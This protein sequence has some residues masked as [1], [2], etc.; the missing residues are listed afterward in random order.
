MMVYQNQTRKAFFWFVAVFLF[1]AVG[2]FLGGYVY[3]SHEEQ[4]IRDHAKSNVVA[5][6]ELKVQQVTNWRGELQSDAAMILDNHMLVKSVQEFLADPMHSSSRGDVLNFM[7]G[8]REHHQ[9]ENIFLFDT[10][11]SVRLGTD[12]PETHLGEHVARD[13][14]RARQ[15]KSILLGDFENERALPEIHLD[16]LVPLFSRG[17]RDTICV[18]V[19]IMQVGPQMLHQIMDVWPVSG[20]T[21]ETLLLRQDGNEVVFLNHLKHREDSILSVRR[22]VSHEHLPAAMAKMLG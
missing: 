18:G 19:M 5:I 11:N 22:L 13:V 15:S 14:E 21:G 4:I 7:L 16:V 8:L 6:A 2:I 9:Y 20:K 10:K 1:V 17:T 12:R 3:Y